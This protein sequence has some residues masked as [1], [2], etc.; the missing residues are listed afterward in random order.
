M[1]KTEITVFSQSKMHKMLDK[2][3]H[4]VDMFEGFKRLVSIDKVEITTKTEIN[5]D[6]YLKIAKGI[7]KGDILGMFAPNGW[8][9]VQVGIKAFSNGREFTF[10]DI[11][12]TIEILKEQDNDR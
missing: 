6:Y 10:I 7:V 2:E 11:D 8:F 1:N 5:D 9:Y 3:M 12:K 4:N